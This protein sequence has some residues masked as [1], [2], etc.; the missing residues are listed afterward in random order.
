M[1]KV[2]EEEACREY[3]VEPSWFERVVHARYNTSS[4]AYTHKSGKS[5][6]VGIKTRY[7]SILCMNSYIIKL[8]A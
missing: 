6:K 1:K 8:Y 7:I 2:D 5:R 4:M 3:T